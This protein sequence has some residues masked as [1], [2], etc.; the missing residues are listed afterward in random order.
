MR[1]D[2]LPKYKSFPV[3]LDE[4]VS[5][6]HWRPRGEDGKHFGYNVA[7]AVD[8]FGRCYVGEAKCS[9][10]D[11]YTK[12]RGFEIAVGRA[13]NVAQWRAADFVLVG[14]QREGV[15]DKEIRLKVW[16]VLRGMRESSLGWIFPV[17]TQA[18][19]PVL[20]RRKKVAE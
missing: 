1:I 18:G 5:V 17:A 13:L 4:L 12:K 3:E 10:R 20:G 19:I 2:Q 6:I 11:Q 8:E 7:V 9:P 16:G 14:V 15:S